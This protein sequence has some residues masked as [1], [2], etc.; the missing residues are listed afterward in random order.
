MEL[1]VP[2]R[3]HPL[4]APMLPLARVAFVSCVPGAC[5][6]RL[7]KLMKPSMG[8]CACMVAGSNNAGMA[9]RARRIRRIIC[10]HFM[11]FSVAPR[12]FQFGRR[13]GE[14]GDSQPRRQSLGDP[15]FPQSPGQKSKGPSTIYYSQTAAHFNCPIEQI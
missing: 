12:R 8:T 15:E 11:F 13:P 9:K 5:G 2:V 10:R 3:L 1:A 6:L 7:S 4:K 14:L